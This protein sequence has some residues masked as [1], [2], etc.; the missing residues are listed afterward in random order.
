MIT[1]IS[2]SCGYKIV[3]KFLKQIPEVV[4]KLLLSALTTAIT[5][6]NVC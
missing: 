6:Q 3:Q 2:E 4:Q 1:E 5:C